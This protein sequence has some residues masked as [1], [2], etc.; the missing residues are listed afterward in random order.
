[1]KDFSKEIRA[2]AIRNALEFG[3][4]N[5]GKVLTK[6]F[7]H[8]LDKK[9]IKAI[10]PKIHE[11]VKEVNSFDEVKLQRE[12]HDLKS[13]VKEHEEREGLPE[14]ENAVEGKV[15]TRLAPEPSKYNH[16]G[17]ALVF[18][19]QSLYAKK[20]KGK[21]ILRFEDTNPEKS[22]KE[23]Y[24]A[25]NEDLKWLGIKWDEE[26]IASDNME[27]Y[28]EL[29]EK[30]ISEKNAY[31]CKCKQ[32]EVKKLREKMKACK[33]RSQSVKESMTHWKD[34]LNR[35]YGEG[36]RTLRLKGDMKS[37]NG[38][39]RDPVIFRISHAKHFIQGEKYA[40]WPMYDFENPVED[41]LNGVT[42]VI[43][44]KE[45]ELRAELHE[46]LLK[47]LKLKMPIV[48]EIGRYEITGAETQGRVIREMIEKK[49]VS[50]W[51]DPRLVTIKALRR[52]GFV[53]KMFE[54]LAQTVGLSKSSGHISPDVLAAV[55]RKIIDA[56]AS[57][58]SFVKNPV[59]LDIKKKPKI[60]EIEVPIHPD[61]ADRKKIEIGKILISGDDFNSLKG[62]EIRL[63][64]LYNIKLDKKTENAEFTSEENKDI[65]KI[66]WVSDKKS[67]KTKILM[68]DG[69]WVKGMAEE[70]ITDLEEG[71]I[72][73]F[74][75]YGFCRFDRV[76]EDEEY[77]FWFAHR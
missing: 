23:F 76:N 16:I 70:A 67:A 68:P 32:E 45:F 11:I 21:C 33:C 37:K 27:K 7:N 77:E 60:K 58:Y 5:S 46:Y 13:V 31:V 14:L 3:K 74:E 20:Y 54:E 72:I 39:M 40:V 34:M 2:Y 73:Q 64:H 4:A 59:E 41:A 51:D 38:V 61:K 71:E 43:R 8:G 30:L 44:S 63:L 65:P 69:K 12:M 42:H 1:M 56:T 47:L 26:I 52:R 24:D 50:G 48:R 36:E 9:D 22:S 17:H 10:M 49:E 6:L 28:Y 35:K 19:I 18:M 62:K 25:M 55:N 66:N 57:R 75:R 15:V 29:A 53:P